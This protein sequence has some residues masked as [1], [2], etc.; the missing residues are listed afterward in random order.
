MTDETSREKIQGESERRLSD[1][2]R[3]VRSGDF[4]KVRALLSSGADVSARSPE[5]RT[6]LHVAAEEG[7]LEAVQLLLDFGAE[8]DARMKY[9]QTPLHRAAMSGYGI[10]L[11]DSDPERPGDERALPG[12]RPVSAGVFYEEVADLLLNRGARI[13]A[14]TDSGDSPLSLAAGMAT[15]AMSRLLVRRGADLSDRSGRR[16]LEAAVASG[17]RETAEILLD[18][19]VEAGRSLHLA[20]ANGAIEMVTLFLGRGAP[21]DLRDEEGDTPLLCASRSGHRIVVQAL[22]GRGAD[23]EAMNSAGRRAMHE[24]GVET[25]RLLVERG[26]A[27]NAQDARGWSPL[28]EAARSQDFEKAEF[29][30]NA[31]AS[32][33]ERADRGDTPLHAIFD[34]DEMYPEASHGLIALLLS[35]GG[36][37]DAA[38]RDG[39]TP[40]SRARKHGCPECLTLMKRGRREV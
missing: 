28:H 26:A 4:P 17:R 16:A 40:T 6:A 31:G 34:A 27:I 15:P 11:C 38:N 33:N 18:S 36:D 35:R 7:H 30:L 32:A 37:P 14:M 9:G 2:H 3:A 12:V 29:L 25:V 8:V 13:D 19:G 23:V 10:E 21:V 20:A 22:L 24:A 5:R 1:L 39:E